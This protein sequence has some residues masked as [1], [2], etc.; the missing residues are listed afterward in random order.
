MYIP[1]SQYQTGFYSNDNF[2]LITN[3]RPYTGPYWKLLK[4][5]YL[6]TGESPNFDSIRILEINPTQPTTP[7]GDTEI[8]P[9]T[10]SVITPIK[11]L[12]KYAKVRVIP[13]PYYLTLTENQKSS[14]SIIRY[15]CKKN[16]QYMYM[17]ISEG[18]FSSLENKSPIIAWDQYDIVNLEWIINGNQDNV[19]KQNKKTILDIE[20]I[21]SGR[22]P[23][24]KYWIGFSQIFKDD[25][26]Q[27]FQGI[28]ENLSTP[29][30]EYKTSDGKEYIGPYHIHPEKGPMVGPTHISTPHD[31]LYPIDLPIPE[32]TDLPSLPTQPIQQQ[33]TSPTYIPPPTGGGISS[34]GG[35]GGY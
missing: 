31:Y 7:T 13:P 2:K 4:N 16:T 20:S 29:G 18:T 9:D 26:L 30:G 33:P 14:S 1:P 28:Q 25:Y 15:F 32:S 3:N 8:P 17:E 35:G 12:G 23:N 27:F 11:D 19:F 5:G 21:N 6:Y 24:G 34:G 22:N 10:T